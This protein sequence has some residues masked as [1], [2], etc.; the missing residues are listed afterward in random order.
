MIRVC[1]AIMGSGKSQSAIAYMNS[2]PDQKFIYITPF[3][4]ETERIRESCPDL[5]FVVP[6]ERIPKFGYTKSGH[7]N[8]LISQGRNIA[9]THQAFKFYTQETID[10]LREAEYTLIIDENINVLDRQ[11]FHEKDIELAIEAGYMIDMGDHY[12][13]SGKDYGG[14]MIAPIVRLIQSRYLYKGRDKGNGT[15]LYF[16][17]LP[18]DLFMAFRDVFILTYLFEGT[19]LYHFLQL[20]ELPYELIGIVRTQD[21]GYMFSDAGDYYIPEYVSELASHIHICQHAKLNALG[22]RWNTLS[23]NWYGCHPEKVDQMRKNVCNYFRHIC[24]EIPAN[25]RLWASYKDHV[26]KLRGKGYANRHIPIN[27]R[28][29]NDYRDRRVLAYTVNLYMNVEY[30]HFMESLGIETDNDGYALS[31]MI[32]WIWRSAIRDGEEIWIY[33]PSRRMRELLQN[34]IAEVSRLGSRNQTA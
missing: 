14:K 8:Y 13:Y 5:H 26:G 21:G 33:I 10:A 11:I 27:S 6:Q 18:V 15:F 32:Q 28:A 16:W 22:D 20:H 19:S 34:W 23:K 17:G 24:A 12:E 2:R 1:D 3:V 30:I 31:T 4:D 25:L 9:T 29:T 7:C